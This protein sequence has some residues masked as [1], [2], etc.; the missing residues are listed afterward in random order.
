MWAF[1]RLVALLGASAVCIVIGSFF[2]TLLLVYEV[3]E[4]F[5][6]MGLLRCCPI[7]SKM[8]EMA[9]ECRYSGV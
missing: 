9:M 8:F 5:R 2:F 1:Y 4:R 7:E 3:Q 6:V